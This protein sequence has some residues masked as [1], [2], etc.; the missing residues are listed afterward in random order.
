MWGVVLALAVSL[1][2]VTAAQAQTAPGAQGYWVLTHLMQLGP[3]ALAGDPGVELHQGTGYTASEADSF[4]ESGQQCADD[5]FPAGEGQAVWHFVVPQGYFVSIHLKF[6]DGTTIDTAYPA[7]PGDA[8]AWVQIQDGHAKGAYVTTADDAVI[9]E[10]T[11]VLGDGADMWNLSHTCVGAAESTGTLEV[12]K[13][14]SPTDDPGTF[15]L[16]INGSTEKDDA[17]H[18]DT[19][20][21]VTVAAGTNTVGEV[22]GA[23]DTTNLADYTSSITCTDETNTARK[24]QLASLPTNAAGPGPVDVTV[25]EDHDIV[26]VITN[27]RNAGTLE[28]V[29]HLSPT[30]DP[31]TFDLQINGQTQ[32]DDAVHNDT[33]GGVPVPSGNNTVGEVEGEGDTTNLDDYTSS[34]TCTDE[35]VVLTR[36]LQGVSLPTDVAGPG[37]VNVD[38]P[39]GHDIVCVIT[40]TRKPEGGGGGGGGTP[41]SSPIIDVKIDKTGVL[42]G[43]QIN[44]TITVTNSSLVQADNVVVTDPAPSGTSIVSVS[45]SQGGCS[46]FPCTLGSLAAGASATIN[47]VT[48]APPAGAEATTVTNVATVSA[49][50]DSNS[51]NNTDDAAVE[52]A[53]FQP[54]AVITCRALKANIKGVAVGK[55][56]TIRIVVRGSNGKGFRTKVTVSGAG[57]KATGRTNRKGVLVIRVKATKPGIITIRAGNG[58]SKRVSAAG[59]FQPPLTG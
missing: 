9:Q 31:G 19:T 10:A 49:T 26:C 48:T 11:A 55:T 54:A 1:V 34:I 23:G 32:K 8:F 56:K 28:V 3:R 57:I 43:D 39:A 25:P 17:A 50:G 38:V 37:P 15:D 41:S 47:V 30:D 46:A 22:E 16:Q 2:I 51:T 13:H 53:A 24:L 7:D 21:A 20:G 18:N 6:S 45:S 14:L 40:N 36:T 12:V 44:W 33:T 29:K 59:A 5:G 4:D 27:T 58:C 52:I 35:T 42:A